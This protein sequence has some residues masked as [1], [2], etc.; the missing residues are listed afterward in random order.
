MVALNL[1]KFS[2]KL[3]LCKKKK[4]FPMFA[5][6]SFYAVNMIFFGATTE[7]QGTGAFYMG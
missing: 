6:K 1:H 2:A 5:R 7:N 4:I 3:N